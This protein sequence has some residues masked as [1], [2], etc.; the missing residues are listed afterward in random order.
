MLEIYQSHLYFANALIALVLLF[1]LVINFKKPLTLK[2]LFLGFIGSIFIHNLAYLLSLDF[3]I[4][5]IC[6]VLIILIGIHIIYL[7]NDFKLNKNLIVLTLFSLILFVFNLVTAKLIQPV[8]GDLLFWVRRINRILNSLGILALFIITFQKMFTSLDEKNQYSKKIKK[9]TKITIT[10]VIIAILNNLSIVLFPSGV[11]VSK[12]ISSLIQLTCCILLVFRPPFL[13]R[14]EL[15]ISLGK[16]F[17]KTLE[18]EVNTDE[19]IKEFFTNTYYA[20]KE[21]TVDDFALKLKVPTKTLNDFIYETTKMNFTDLVNKNRV[22][23][24]INLVSNKD[25]QQYS[26][27]GLAELAGFGS[28][29]SLY[30]NFKKF[31]GGSPSD[32]IRMY[33]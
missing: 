26:V 14:T 11:F 32:L 21:I 10:L 9:W 20:N 18:D 15:S 13:N 25:H 7:L 16:G 2:L 27:E 24:Y 12:I 23:F 31:H 29:Q 1:E 5:E 4:R 8:N 17:R 3:I 6:R 28:R 30:R 19:F 22:E 33:K